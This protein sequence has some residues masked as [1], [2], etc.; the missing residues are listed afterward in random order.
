MD[1]MKRQ[2][3]EMRKSMPEL[4]QFNQQQWEQ[5]KRDMKQLQF[6]ISRHV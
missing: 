6:G 4:F 3:E 5:F 1:E 2:M